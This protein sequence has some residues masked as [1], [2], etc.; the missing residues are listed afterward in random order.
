VA[1]IAKLHPEVKSLRDA[2]MDMVES[3]LAGGDIKVY[4]RCK[5]IVGEIARLQAGCKDL[6]AGDIAAFGLKMFETHKGLSQEYE[7]SCSELDFLAD[8]A[9]TQTAVIGARMMG[10]GFGGCTIN[11]V[12]DA[13]VDNFIAGAALA[14]KNRFEQDLKSYI[15]A[16]GDGTSLINN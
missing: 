13:E 8:Y 10:G 5:F 2:S 9:K 16:I 4:Q 14:F 15:V 6:V 7:V 3:I 1:A 12:K 11:L